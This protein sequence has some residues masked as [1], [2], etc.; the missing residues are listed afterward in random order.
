MTGSDDGTT[1]SGDQP[2]PGGR[3][4]PDVEKAEPIPVTE[5]MITPRTTPPDSEQGADVEI[6]FCHSC[7]ER[8]KSR[9]PYCLGCGVRFL[10]PAEPAQPRA[11]GPGASHDAPVTNEATRDHALA[12]ATGLPTSDRERADESFKPPSSVSAPGRGFR[13][14]LIMIVVIAI[15]V[16]GFSTLR[17]RDGDQTEEV[18]QP[19]TSTTA[20]PDAG[21]ELRGYADEIAVLADDVADLRATGLRI[22][23]D[24][25]GRTTD[26]QTTVGRMTA[27]VSRAVVLPDRLTGLVLPAEVDPFTH[28][29]MV[30]ALTTLASAA[31]GMMDGLESTDAGD[32]RLEQLSHF[33]TAASA[34]GALANE[35]ESLVDAIGAEPG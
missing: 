18:E 27:L 12:G 24:W 20:A 9:G 16:V 23:A 26:Y 5:A 22:N 4:R 30:E 3:R 34:F 11:A 29:R 7:G 8:N 19:S 14:V 6:R 13:S 32:A 21:L 33:Q 17:S 1:P 31:E 35:V 10:W 2:L 28:Q 25:G 15:L